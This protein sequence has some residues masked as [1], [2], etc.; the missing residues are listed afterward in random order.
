MQGCKQDVLIG[1][2]SP[3]IK[4]LPG[5]ITNRAAMTETLMDAESPSLHHASATP[6]H[7]SNPVSPRR[8]EP[9]GARAPKLY[10]VAEGDWFYKI[11]KAQG[12]SLKSLAE[13]NPGVDSAKLKVGQTL[14]LPEPK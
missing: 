10:T 2:A 3:A 13:A 11:A 14:K 1:E 7:S 12:I 4:D 9:S 6:A 5:Q 8:V